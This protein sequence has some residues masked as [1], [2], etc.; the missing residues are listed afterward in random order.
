[1]KHVIYYFDFN[2]FTLNLIYFYKLANVNTK[3]TADVFIQVQRS[4]LLCHYTIQI[5]I[6]YIEITFDTSTYN[7]LGKLKITYVFLLYYVHYV[8]MNL[9]PLYLLKKPDLQPL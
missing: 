4:Q 2:Y 5:P 3:Y 9:D 6:Y 7:W 1:M 8:Y